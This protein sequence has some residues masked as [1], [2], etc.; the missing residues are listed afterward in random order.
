LVR[1]GHAHVRKKLQRVP[2]VEVIHDL[3][4]SGRGEGGGG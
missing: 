1:I 3:T 4:K 2:R